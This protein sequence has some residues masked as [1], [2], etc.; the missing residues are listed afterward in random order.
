MGWRCISSIETGVGSNQDG[1]IATKAASGPARMP[2]PSTASRPS[3]TSFPWGRPTMKLPLVQLAVP[4]WK[5]TRGSAGSPPWTWRRQR[6]RCISISIRVVYEMATCFSYLYLGC[7]G[8]SPVGPKQSEELRGG[9]GAGAAGRRL[10]AFAFAI[11]ITDNMYLAREHAL[12]REHSSLCLLL[13]LCLSLSLR[14]SSS[15]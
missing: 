7:S 3:P 5:T 8:C 13:G 14:R 1:Q 10:F 6:P 12:P 9:G 4:P 11:T 2:S 15:L